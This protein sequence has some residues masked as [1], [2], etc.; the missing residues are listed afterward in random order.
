MSAEYRAP[1]DPREWLNRAKSNLLQAQARQEGVYL[2]DLCFNAQQ[3][4]EKAIKAVLIHLNVEYPYIHDLAALLTLVGRAGLG[5]P[6]AVKEAARLTRYAVTTRYP[7]VAEPVTEEEN[8][9]AVAI[10]REV[11]QWAEEVISG[12]S[13]L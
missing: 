6:E 7:G 1:D 8:T 13:G 9:Q 11:L 2:E 4:A 3:A 5:V 12:R 10:A